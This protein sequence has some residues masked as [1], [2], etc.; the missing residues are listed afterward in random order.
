MDVYHVVA[1][2]DSLHLRFDAVM[3]FPQ[4][5]LGSVEPVDV[6]ERLLDYGGTFAS[7]GF[8]QHATFCGRRLH[9]R[10]RG[11]RSA[12]LMRC[13]LRVLGITCIEG[14]VASVLGDD[15]EVRF[16]RKVSDGGFH[17]HDVLGSCGFPGDDVHR[18]DV[19]VGHGR[20]KKDVYGLVEAHFDTAG[21]ASSAAIVR[22]RLDN[23]FM[24]VLFFRQ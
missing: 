4:P 18:P 1:D 7:G 24:T 11:R 20:R 9:G 22:K 3:F 13:D 6:V 17:A 5:H 23:R 2:V 10:G 15:R 19:D 14:V 16:F 21:A 12:Y 8:E